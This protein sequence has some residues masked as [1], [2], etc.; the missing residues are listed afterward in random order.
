MDWNISNK[1]KQKMQIKNCK[2]WNARDAYKFS[3]VVHKIKDK[4]KAEANFS[5]DGVKTLITGKAKS[6][7]KFSL[8][9]YLHLHKNDLIDCNQNKK[10]FQWHLN[11]KQLSQPWTERS[12]LSLLA[13]LKAKKVKWDRSQLTKFKIFYYQG[14]SHKK[15]SP[16]NSKIFK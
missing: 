3:K 6:W 13:L 5:N 4:N 1:S 15:P 11:Q 9:L 8:F 12:R 16:R 2:C 10:S 7:S 14:L